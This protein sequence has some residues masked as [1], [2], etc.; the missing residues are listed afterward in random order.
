MY[1]KLSSGNKIIGETK[2]G[3]I[4]IFYVFLKQ[5]R[6]VLGVFRGALRVLN[7]FVVSPR[8]R[9]GMPA[10]KLLA[11]SKTDEVDFFCYF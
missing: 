2:N 4:I 10:I 8:T 5:I 9:N 3:E 1:W 6:A 7:F 11:T